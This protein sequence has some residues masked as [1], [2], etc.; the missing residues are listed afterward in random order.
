MPEAHT[1]Q[2][3]IINIEEHL[4][5]HSV[6][7]RFLEPFFIL[8]QRN[9]PR[10][11]RAMDWPQYVNVP[12]DTL[13]TLRANYI[14]H[15]RGLTKMFMIQYDGELVGVL[16]FNQIEAA[17]KTAYIGYWLDEA[18]QGQGIVSRALQ[19]LMHKYAQKGAIRRFVIRCIVSNA[20]SNRVAQRNGFVLEACLRQAEYLNGRYHDQNIYARIIDV[21]QR[22]P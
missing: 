11:Q 3:E 4:Y 8:I 10:L 14:L 20:A 6:N 17:S 1:W 2:D 18:V 15:H 5:L 16:S 12:Q 21:S 13:K 22:M 7:E 19:A 9:K